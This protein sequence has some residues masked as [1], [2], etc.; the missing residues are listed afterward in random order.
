MV[1]QRVLL[2]AS[3]DLPLTQ[4]NIQDP[5]ERRQPR[6]VERLPAGR[7]LGDL[8][9]LAQERPE[10]AMRAPTA[11]DDGDDQWPAS[12]AHTNHSSVRAAAAIAVEQRTGRS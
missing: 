7:C 2:P 9:Q 1:R 5:E 8:V 12:A 11:H 4:R 10:A 6:H 3:G